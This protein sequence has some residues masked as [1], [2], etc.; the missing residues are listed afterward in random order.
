[1]IKETLGTN[2]KTLG[3][4]EYESEVLLA[5][6]LKGIADTRELSILSKVPRTRI[7]DVLNSL[8]SKGWIVE[9]PGRP[10]LYEMLDFEN[11]LKKTVSEK[12]TELEKLETNALTRIKEIKEIKIKKGRIVED[13]ALILGTDNAINEIRRVLRGAKKHVFLE[14][15]DPYV[16]KE[17]KPDFKELKNRGVII[18]AFFT[19]KDAKKIRKYKKLMK[20]KIAPAKYAAGLIAT[21]K[22][23]VKV[24][25]SG[26]VVNIEKD[27]DPVCALCISRRMKNDWNKSR[28]LR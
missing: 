23:F 24:Y 8:I 20:I 27:R 17:L 14:D 19:E 13:T 28:E 11:L 6:L 25:V 9:R 18:N 16:M 26:T 21:E 22:E 15:V 4:T 7:Y 3:F 10:A 12:K 2:L 1:M 5:L